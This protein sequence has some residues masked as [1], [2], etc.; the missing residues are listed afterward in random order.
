MTKK[1]EKYYRNRAKEYDLVYQKP[2]RQTDLKQLHN[3]LKKA[4]KDK[5][6][7]EIACGTG[8]WTETIAKVSTNVLATDIAEEVLSIAK[9]K[10]YEQKNVRFEKMDFWQLED[11]QG[12]FDC[13]F[14][15][16]IWSHILKKD[17]SHFLTILSNQLVE[18]GKLIFIDN[19]YIEGSSTPI[20]RMDEERNTYQIRKLQTGAEYEVLKN[21]PNEEEVVQLIKDFG[22]EMEWL[23]LEYFWIL[24]MRKLQENC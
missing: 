5:V 21:F 6:V 11:A 3:Y 10:N 19:K 14:G 23:E 13:V 7:F 22:F 2:E 15:G 9:T 17:L 18:N 16:F 8:Y 4:L 12:H 24:R 1:L 20:S